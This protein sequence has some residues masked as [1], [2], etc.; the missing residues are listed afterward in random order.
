MRD[1]HVAWLAPLFSTPELISHIFLRLDLRW[2]LQNTIKTTS[3]NWTVKNSKSRHIVDNW[4]EQSLFPVKGRLG[5]SQWRLRWGC[6]E[7]R[8]WNVDI[9]LVCLC[10]SLYCYF[11][12]SSCCDVFYYLRWDLETPLQEYVLLSPPTSPLAL[13]GQTGHVDQPIP[14]CLK[15]TWTN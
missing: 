10:I 13:L 3:H 11:D 12:C 2:R 1:T 4:F 6:L 7:G 15:P 9:E 14:S 5:R 8:T